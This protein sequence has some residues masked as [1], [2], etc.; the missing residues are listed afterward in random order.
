MTAAATTFIG[1]NPFTGK[2]AEAVKPV[3]KANGP[4]VFI[5]LATLTIANDPL[6]TRR[7]VAGL[8]YDALFSALQVGQCIVCAPLESGKIGSALNAWLHKKGLNNVV[9]TC[10]NY[11]TDEKGRV[12]LLEPVVRALKQAA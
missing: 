2:P 12:W 11:E 4:T 5:D 9:K 6:P 7:V 1:K 10:R 8:K 3:K